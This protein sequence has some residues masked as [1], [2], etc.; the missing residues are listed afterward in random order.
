MLD[1]QSGPTPAPA[2]AQQT[3]NSAGPQQ[4][5]RILGIMP[6]FSAVSADTKLPPQTVKEKFIIAGKN[7]FDYSSFVIAAIQSGI[8]HERQL[9]P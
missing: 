8:C 6:N 1:Q 7:S 9:L 5:K 4:T 3:T 2:P